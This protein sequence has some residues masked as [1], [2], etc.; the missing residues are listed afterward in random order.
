MARRDAEI[1]DEK[2][3]GGHAYCGGRCLE[4]N[5][6]QPWDTVAMMEIVAGSRRNH[7][8]GTENTFKSAY[9]TIFVLDRL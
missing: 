4:A 7:E 3:T 2:S 5:Y 9:Y 1:V 6:H 8:R